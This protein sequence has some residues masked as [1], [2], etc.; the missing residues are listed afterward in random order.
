MP[1]ET[2]LLTRSLKSKS[3]KRKNFSELPFDKLKKVNS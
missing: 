1:G 2:I 3:D